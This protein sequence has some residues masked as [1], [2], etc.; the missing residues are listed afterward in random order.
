MKKIIFCSLIIAVMTGIIGCSRGAKS[1]DIN[2]ISENTMLA[3]ANGTLQVATV[4]EFNK[5]Y[6]S[7]EE[8][9]EFVK[10]QVDAYNAKA[11]GDKVT[12]GTND[13]L[14]KNDKA[15]M[16]LTYSGMDQYTAFNEVT[17]AYFT[18]GIK[19][20]PLALPDSLVNAGNN[21]QTGTQEVIQ[22]G[23]YKILVVNEP[24]NIVVDGKLKYYSGNAKLLE[25][26]VVRSADEGMTVIVFKP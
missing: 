12:I 11:G 5:D 2:E 3:R 23:K 8:L 9:T 18:G 7:F 21:S 13:L 22:N 19:D 17:A 26:D 16:L 10:N 15:I 25:D 14:K 1:L 24:Y 6:Y 20:N 4:E